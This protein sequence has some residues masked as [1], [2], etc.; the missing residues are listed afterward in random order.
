MNVRFLSRA[1]PV[2]CWFLVLGLGAQEAAAP[3][4]APV[5]ALDQLRAEL[6]ILAREDSWHDP[7]DEIK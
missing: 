3:A 2:V 6:R 5:S 7:L 1:F 4:A